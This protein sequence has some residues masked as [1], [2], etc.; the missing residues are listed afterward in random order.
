MRTKAPGPRQQFQAGV[1]YV[2]L[3]AVSQDRNA[4]PAR[5]PNTGMINQCLGPKILNARGGRSSPALSVS[6]FSPGWGVPSSHGLT[7][8]INCSSV[9][10][11][12]Y[13]ILGRINEKFYSVI[14]E[15]PKTILKLCR[16]QGY[17]HISTSSTGAFTRTEATG[18]DQKLIKSNFIQLS[19]SHNESA[20]QCAMRS[21]RNNLICRRGRYTPR[22]RSELFP[23]IHSLSD[24][25]I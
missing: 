4:Y 16:R 1:L 20:L 5:R 23:Q 11:A 14:E 9:T 24:S 17:F 7:E 6:I 3:D 15:K 25:F 10:D 2:I 19:V 12:A 8:Y 21:E 22:G 13:I 18:S